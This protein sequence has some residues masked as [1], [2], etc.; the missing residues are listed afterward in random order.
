ML[1]NPICVVK[2]GMLNSPP[3][4][5][6]WE[7]TE[8]KTSVV[9]YGVGALVV[10][11]LTSTIVGAVNNVPLVRTHDDLTCPPRKHSRGG[12]KR[13]WVHGKAGRLKNRKQPVSSAGRRRQF[14][15]GHL[16]LCSKLIQRAQLAASLECTQ[17]VAAP[18]AH[19]CAH[20]PACS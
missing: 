15:A 13:S 4:C 14:M 8:N 1:P 20:C 12:G 2:I 18:A 9:L 10:V 17:I 3:V 11:W 5:V 16:E 7:N 6:Q 19:A